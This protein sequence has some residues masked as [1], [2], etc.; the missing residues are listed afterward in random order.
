MLQ[1]GKQSLVQFWKGQL[2]HLSSYLQTASF[3]LLKFWKKKFEP[4]IGNWLRSIIKIFS[5]KMHTQTK[6]GEEV[7]SNC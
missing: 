7:Q 2:R 3:C 6:G 5:F 4:V 1:N